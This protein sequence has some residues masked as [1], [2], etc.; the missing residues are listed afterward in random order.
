MGLKSLR[1][2]PAKHVLCRHGPFCRA[3]VS[4]LAVEVAAG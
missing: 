1:I 4:L 3:F 2:G